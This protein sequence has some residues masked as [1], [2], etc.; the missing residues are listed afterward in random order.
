[1][2]GELGGDPTRVLLRATEALLA[3]AGRGGVVVGVDD[4]P[5]LDDLSALLVHQLVLRG[6]ATVVITVR[7]GEPTPDAVTAL[8]KDGH[9]DRLEVQPLSEP[10]T[11][12]GG[13]PAIA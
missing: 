1:L 3:G 12:S 2:V 5:L 10:E 13:R 6:A 7:T 9:L 11:F 8:W 4:A